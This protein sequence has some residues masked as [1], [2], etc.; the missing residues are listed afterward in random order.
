[1]S[2]RDPE[3]IDFERGDVLN[4][5]WWRDVIT[6]HALLDR[7]D[8][9]LP[10]HEQE[11]LQDEFERVVGILKTAPSDGPTRISLQPRPLAKVLEPFCDPAEDG[12]KIS[13]EH[14]EQ[15]ARLLVA[16]AESWQNAC[17]YLRNM[18]ARS[19]KLNMMYNENRDLKLENKRLKKRVHELE[20]E[21]A[22]LETKVEIYSTP[23][24]VPSSEAPAPP[25]G[26][27]SG[28]TPP[29]QDQGDADGVPVS[30]TPSEDDGFQDVYAEFKRGLSPNALQ[31]LE[32]LTGEWQSMD[33]I[34]DTLDVVKKTARTYRADLEDAVEGSE[35]YAV[36]DILEVERRGRSKKF[37][38]GWA[39][40]Q[41]DR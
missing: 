2:H 23:S 40:Q 8:L 10:N 4:N 17:E 15:L 39:A 34:A 9:E 13:A 3:Q 37:R 27:D 14:R 11:Q 12:Y 30:E 32:T 31:F 25:M 36:S 22:T 21:Q 1:M 33:E 29:T 35:E 18:D 20:I 19:K 41:S 16:F 24:E 28:Q 26:V 7:D 38:V 6:A 5:S